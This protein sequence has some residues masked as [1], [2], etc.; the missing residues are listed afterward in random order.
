MTT[1]SGLL[2]LAFLGSELGLAWRRR[3]SREPK[4]HG[5]DDGSLAL[6]WRVI[7]CAMTAGFLLAVFDVGPR[8]PASVP[9]GPISLGVFAV[10][11]LLRWWAIWHLGQFFTVDVAVA[12]DQCVVDTGPYRWVRHPSYSGLLLQFT[13]V[14]LALF[15]CLSLAVIILPIGW[16]LLHRIR[17]E[18]KALSAALGDA[19]KKYAS[20]TRRL[21]PLVY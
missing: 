16:A 12:D 5:M 20:A 14:G 18:E 15:H 19:Y 21:V 13:G 17:V 4:S 7:G 1:V 10:G 8:L 6:L 11:T 3:A 2:G 9:W